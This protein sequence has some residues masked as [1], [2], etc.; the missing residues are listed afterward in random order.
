MRLRSRRLVP[1]SGNVECLM[2]NVECLM[3]CKCIEIKKSLF[4]IVGF[5]ILI[6]KK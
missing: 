2:L 3:N 5:Y 4:T 1:Q 6:I